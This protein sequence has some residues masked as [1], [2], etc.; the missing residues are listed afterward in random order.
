MKAKIY[1]CLLTLI[2]SQNRAQNIVNA[3]EDNE[4]DGF[5]SM[6]S[7][8]TDRNE[9]VSS[10]MDDD[11][12]NNI[13]EDY[14]TLVR[15]SP[16]VNITLKVSMRQIV[17]VDIQNQ[18]I[19]TNFYLSLIWLDR[20]LLWIP[21]QFGNLKSILIPSN[22]I[23]T[24]DL[25][26]MNGAT[27]NGFIKISSS[28]LAVVN[29]YG[30]VY[31]IL[32]IKGQTTRCKMN[33]M[34]Y[35]FDAQNCSIVIGSWQHDLHKIN[36]DSNVNK[37][38]LTNYISNPVWNLLQV[39]VKSVITSERYIKVLNSSNEDISF[40][41]LIKRR[42]LYIMINNVYPVLILNAVTLLSFFLPFVTQ[43]TLSMTT[44]L[45]YGVYSVR[46]AADLPIQSEVIPHISVYYFLAIMNTFISLNWF[47]VVNSIGTKKV[48]PKVLKPFTI[49]VKLTN[50]TLTNISRTKLSSKKK[51]ADVEVGLKERAQNQN[52]EPILPRKKCIKCETCDYCVVSKERENEKKVLTEIFDAE[53]YALNLFMFFLIFMT[54]L[55]SNLALW[56]Q[57][58]S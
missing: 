29:N 28:N 12:M 52:L 19:T 23:W 48:I 15:P 54:I 6:Q 41:F 11:I 38:D 5:S 53:L 20:R 36:F 44:F 49:L 2:L 39:Q 10:I 1:L 46:T 4:D 9:L 55:V 50:S 35:P 43:V 14:N 57:I 25:S 45:T 30:L 7:N 21:S 3:N 34:K 26:I 56:L 32:N 8:S 18:I 47:F 24:P 51:I 22:K 16:L 37:I 13:T 31:L 33:V 40:S 42:P 58:A 27:G 17:S